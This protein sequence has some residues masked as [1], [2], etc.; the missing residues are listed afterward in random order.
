[1]K[2]LKGRIGVAAALFVTAALVCLTMGQ[3]KL[4]AE[5]QP[6]R[7]EIIRN[8]TTEIKMA[9]NIIDDLDAI[10]QQSQQQKIALVEVRAVLT[11]WKETL[12]KSPKQMKLRGATGEFIEAAGTVVIGGLIG[13]VPGAIAGAGKVIIDTTEKAIEA[14]EK[15][16]EKIEKELE[17]QKERLKEQK[18]KQKE[19][20]K[21]P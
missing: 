9:D 14:V 8:L 7:E 2:T 17:E 3:D 18:R 20:K 6:S 12:L 1:M 15:R 11:A 4:S 13:G 19:K 16:N 5:E 21:S 10:I